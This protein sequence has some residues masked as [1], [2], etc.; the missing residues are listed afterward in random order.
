M[1]QAAVPRISPGNAQNRGDRDYQEDAFGFTDRSDPAFVRHAGVAAVLC[2][3]MGGLQFGAESAVLAVDTFLDEYRRKLLNEQPGAALKRA[4]LRANEAVFR[5]ARENNV[6]QRTGCTLVAVV[7]RGVELHCVHA[8]DSRAY[9]YSGGRL[10]RLTTDHTYA[11]RLERQVEQGQLTPREAAEHPQRDHLT[12]NLGR[13]D[14]TELDLLDPPKKLAPNDWILLCSDGLHGMLS[15]AEIAAELHGSSQDAAQRLVQRVTERPEPEKDNVTVVILQVG[16]DGAL[17][18]SHQTWQS[19]RHSQAALEPRRP[20]HSPT[21]SVARSVQPATK[22]T[23]AWIWPLTTLPLVLAIST[24]LLWPTKKPQQESPLT[25][26]F[27]APA[28]QTPGGVASSSVGPKATQAAIQDLPNRPLPTAP[29]ADKSVPSPAAPPKPA[30]K[31]VTKPT[32]APAPAPATPPK[33]GDA[34]G[35]VPPKDAKQPENLKDKLAG[36]DKG[37]SGVT[38]P[39]PSPAPAPN[40][41]AHQG[42]TVPSAATVTPAPAPTVTTG[43]AAG[44]T[45]KPGATAQPKEPSKADSADNKPGS[46]LKI[47]TGSN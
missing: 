18:P 7:A 44:P 34:K 47:D 20:A 22:K 45:A 46:G 26:G 16:T 39:P 15:D 8:G 37:N 6:V 24:W 25:A 27:D 41:A 35:V 23:P 42:N 12:S 43:P 11:R 9:L 30:T 17:L 10:E 33:D 36:S 3:G 28:K 1:M 32:P 29:P 2:D 40:G 19:G 5:F 13:Q 21:E 31:P 4:A 38:Q 14:L